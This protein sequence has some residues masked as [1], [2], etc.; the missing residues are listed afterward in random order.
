MSCLKGKSK[1]KA[2]PGNYECKKCGAVVKIKGK[3]CK[4]SKIKE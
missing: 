1:T 4:P 3:V 2:K